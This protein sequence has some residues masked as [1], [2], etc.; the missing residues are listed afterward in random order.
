MDSPEQAAV[1]QQSLAQHTPIVLGRWVGVLPEICF[2]LSQQQVKPRT[3]IAS[4]S[5]NWHRWAWFGSRIAPNLPHE[6]EPNTEA[7]VVVCKH[8]FQEASGTAL[9]CDDVRW[10]SKQW[11]SAIWGVLP[12][13]SR[14]RLS[15]FRPLLPFGTNDSNGRYGVV[16]GRRSPAPTKPNRERPSGVQQSLR[17]HRLAARPTSPKRQSRVAKHKPR[18][19]MFVLCRY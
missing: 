12:L 11:R 8:S 15:A 2:S 6:I 3:A 7:Y 5:S 18:R 9:D 13:S 16:I 17:N 14:N 10:I 19:P 1:I 4:Q